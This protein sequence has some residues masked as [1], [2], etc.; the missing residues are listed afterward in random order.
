MVHIDNRSDLYNAS[1]NFTGFGIITFEPCFQESAN[2]STLFADNFP[3]GGEPD[4]I[5]NGICGQIFNG[6]YTFNATGE[7]NNQDNLIDGDYTNSGGEGNA[8]MTV[9]YSKPSSAVSAIWMVKQPGIILINLSINDTC[10]DFYEGK[11]VL[12]TSPIGSSMNYKCWNGTDFTLLRTVVSTNLFGEGAIWWNVSV[13]RYPRNVTLN[14]SSEIIDFPGTLINNDLHQNLF[15]LD[16]TYHDKVNVTY[17]TAGSKTI[18]INYSTQGNVLNRS[19]KLNFTINAFDIDVN[20]EFD[21]TNDFGNTSL[22]GDD[23]GTNSNMGIW[24]N[25]IDN[26]TLSNW[27]GDP[28]YATSDDD[29]YTELDYYLYK[30]TTDTPISIYSNTINAFDLSKIVLNLIID[31]GQKYIPDAYFYG[32][33]KVSFTDGE[34]EVIIVSQ[35][36]ASAS[37]SESR[38]HAFNMTLI[39]ISSTSWKIEYFRYHVGEDATIFV[40]E[41][42]STATLNDYYLNFNINPTG[43]GSLKIYPINYSGA[44]INRTLTNSSFIGKEGIGQ[45]HSS[46]FTTHRINETPDNIVAATLNATVYNPENTTIN[47]WLSNDNGTTWESVSNGFKHTFIS[48]GNESKARFELKTEVNLTSPAIL[49]YNV[50]V[51]SSPIS[52]LTINIGDEN[53]VIYDFI[54]ENCLNDIS[55]YRR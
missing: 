17:T 53:L 16:G 48:T 8:N 31:Y 6:T 54:L 18:F 49:S 25:F 22:K 11:I 2:D 52:S 47:Y 45:L 38:V 4:N 5:S 42:V 23:N 40:T 24:E 43:T 50:K 15:I 36:A 1:I 7:F 33:Y 3:L 10:F 51:V 19:K 20:N 28:S 29:Y 37:R 14:V 46:N 55:N 9:N 26:A 30:Q 35:G 34:D 27:N 32:S 44:W 39:K 13:T 21:Y 41:T 12:R